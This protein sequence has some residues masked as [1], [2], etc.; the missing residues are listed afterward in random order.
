MVWDSSE[1][2]LPFN[3]TAN[4]DAFY[5]PNLINTMKYTPEMHRL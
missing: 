2:S 4:F 1:V 5:K 3:V